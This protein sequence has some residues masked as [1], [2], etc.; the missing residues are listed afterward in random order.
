M[1][2]AAGE[3]TY[4]GQPG[5]ARPELKC[6]GFVLSLW[7]RVAR[8]KLKTAK[9]HP[10]IDMVKP[11]I[12]ECLLSIQPSWFAVGTK[13]T[14]LGELQPVIPTPF[15]G[16]HLGWLKPNLNLGHEPAEFLRFLDCFHQDLRPE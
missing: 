3:G 7:G 16:H 14:S 9:P 10:V 13:A 15:N 6:R 2:S 5:A 12:T 1:A 11:R 4:Y 8:S